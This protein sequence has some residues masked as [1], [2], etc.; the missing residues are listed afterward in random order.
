ME[1]RKDGQDEADAEDK[2]EGRQ[3][4]EAIGDGET[5]SNGTKRKMLAFLK[6]KRTRK[7]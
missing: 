6:V 3:E 1:V 7:L 4:K 2:V 5:K